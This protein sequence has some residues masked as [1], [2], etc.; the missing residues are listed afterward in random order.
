MSK[1]INSEKYWKLKSSP[2]CFKIQNIVYRTDES[3]VAPYGIKRVGTFGNFD[4][5]V[6]STTLSKLFP[7][8]LKW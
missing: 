7:M 2:D 3:S 8:L 4:F 1:I 5:N 6:E